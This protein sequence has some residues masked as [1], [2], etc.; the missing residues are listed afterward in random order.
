MGKINCWEFKKCGRETGG[1][2]AEKLGV[3]PASKQEKTNGINNGKFAGRCCWAVAGT[4]CNGPVQ[5]T[6][7]QEINR[8]MDC[9]FYWIV[10]HEEGKEAMTLN[11]ILRIVSK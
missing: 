10:A 11:E 4:L 5:G 8:C 7:A 1:K 9:E 6:F 2:N 3:C